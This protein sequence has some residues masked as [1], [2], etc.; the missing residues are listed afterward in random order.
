MLR[1][2]N[3]LVPENATLRCPYGDF[4]TDN[5]FLVLCSFSHYGK[6]GTESYKDSKLCHRNRQQE[7]V[8]I[9]HQ[10]KKK[11]K[12]TIHHHTFFEHAILQEYKGAAEAAK[13]D[14]Q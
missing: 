2:G 6:A 13:L 5:S 12:K 1:F 7:H 3:K 14:L 4:I 10:G 8:L 9:L 11:K